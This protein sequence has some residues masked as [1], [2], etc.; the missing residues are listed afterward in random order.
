[1]FDVEDQ[2]PEWLPEFSTTLS[3]RLMRSC[4]RQRLVAA[5]SRRTEEKVASR[6][7]SGRHC[8]KA[9]RARAL[10]LRLI[11]NQYLGISLEVVILPKKAAYD[12]FEKSCCL[13]FHQ[14][15]NHVAQDCPNSVETLVCSTNV[16]QSMVIQE[17]LLDDEDCYSL[18]QLRPGFHDSQA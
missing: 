11:D 8:R 13:L 1:M 7:G 17:N 12:M 9:S 3:D 4:A 6:R 18:A 15:R 2:I 5:S 10:S 16:I 14:L